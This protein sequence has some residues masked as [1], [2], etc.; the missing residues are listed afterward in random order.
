MCLEFVGSFFNFL[1][2]KELGR[3]IRVLNMRY[4][5]DIFFLSLKFFRRS[6]FLKGSV[7]KEGFF[8]IFEDFFREGVFFEK[9]KKFEE[10]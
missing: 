7:E 9:G 4:F 1:F 2:L 8:G 5:D 10:G 6:R 3:R